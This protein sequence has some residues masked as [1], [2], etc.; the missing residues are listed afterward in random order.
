M[1]DK[2]QI[3][4]CQGPLFSKILLFAF[5]LL[6]TNIL[7]LLFHTADLVVIGHFASHEAMAAIGSTGSLNSLYVNIFIGLSI[8]ANVLAARYSGEQNPEKIRQ[9]CPHLRKVCTTQGRLV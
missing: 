4:M 9:N 6:M 3:D 8:G 2:F 7:Q 5:P 1:K